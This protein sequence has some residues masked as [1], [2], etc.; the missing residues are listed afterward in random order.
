LRTMDRCVDTRWY[1]S[2]SSST[3]APV[4]LR[5]RLTRYSSRSHAGRWAS[6]NASTSTP[7][8]LVALAVVVAQPEPMVTGDAVVLDVAI[9]QLPVRA[10][11][12]LIDLTV[13]FVFYLVGIALWAA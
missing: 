8:T 4:S 11:A 12:A 1:R 13:V 3:S 6:T 5:R 7:R 9:A 10:L 2:T